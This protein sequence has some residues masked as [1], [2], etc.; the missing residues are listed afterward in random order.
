MSII[1][2]KTQN[3]YIKGIIKFTNVWAGDIV[4]VSYH[5]K[6]NYLR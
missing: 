3:K 6:N 1:V 2:D 4:E 5:I